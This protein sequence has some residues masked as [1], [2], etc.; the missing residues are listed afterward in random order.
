MDF[1]SRAY[2][3]LQPSVLLRFRIDNLPF[4]FLNWFYYQSSTL[5]RPRATLKMYSRQPSSFAPMGG[6]RMVCLEDGY[7]RE[8]L[9]HDERFVAVRLVKGRR[10]IIPR[11]IWY[12]TEGVGGTNLI[13]AAG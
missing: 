4:T 1:V 9:D 13:A 10:P 8:A 7:A 12:L 5:P 2:A 3:N 6:D 11:A